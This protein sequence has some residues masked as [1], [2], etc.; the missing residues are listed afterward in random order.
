MSWT[1]AAVSEMR[2]G[3]QHDIEVSEGD[4]GCKINLLAPSGLEVGQTDQFDPPPRPRIKLTQYHLTAE[5]T[6]PAD[7]LQ[8]VT[9][10]WPYRTGAEVAGTARLERTDA[11]YA[12]S[13][14]LAEGKAI[15]LWRT[16]E[17]DLAGY[18]LSTDADIAALRLNAE[19]RP[20]DCFLSGGEQL[21]FAGR[22]LEG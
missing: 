16:D 12:I 10:I 2:I 3:G 14:D 5:T 7:R 13:A 17:G 22:D 1:L 4:A 19:G 6:E 11:G 8:F 9:L 18:G 15:V 21:R 20:A